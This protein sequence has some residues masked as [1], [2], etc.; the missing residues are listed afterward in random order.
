MFRLDRNGQVQREFRSPAPT[1]LGIVW[2]GSAFQLFTT[3]QRHIYEFVIE[4]DRL[5]VLRSFETPVT[6]LG[7][8]ISHDLAWDG[9]S[10]YLVDRFSV[11]KIDRAGNS[12]SLFTTGKE[13]AALE[14]AGD[15]FWVAYRDFPNTAILERRDRAGNPLS[16]HRLPVGEIVA[17]AWAD[18]NLWA[19]GR[20]TI[21]AR[22]TDVYQLDVSRI[23]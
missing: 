1:P 9:E 2:T 3:D 15:V 23:R 20:E 19:L 12:T 22:E 4:Q 14:W 8:G 16:R 10:I 18:G 11:F 17:F 6:T 21:T 7:G 13:I 5:R